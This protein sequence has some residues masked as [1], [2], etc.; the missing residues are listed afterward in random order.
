MEK[1]WIGFW[2]FG[3]SV[4]GMGSLII[5]MIIGQNN[6]DSFTINSNKPPKTFQES[7]MIQDDYDKIDKYVVY[8]TDSIDD[9]VS[10]ESN[11]FDKSSFM[12]DY[13]F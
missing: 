11:T 10:V 12:D 8:E 6:S 13:D 2:I 5:D 9:D 1:I 4:I 3:L 7:Y